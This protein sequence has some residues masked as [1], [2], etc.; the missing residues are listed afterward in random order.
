MRLDIDRNDDWYESEES[1][2]KGMV[3]ELRRIRR[4]F[5]VR[6][7]PVL[8]LAA[9]ITGVLTYKLVTR[10]RTYGAEVVLA[11]R[12]GSLGT[13]DRVGMPVSELKEFVGSVLIPDNKLEELIERRNM[14][15]L[16]NRLGMNWAVAELRTQFEIDVWR[17]SYIYFDPDLP[18]R[19]PSAR[20]GISYYDDDPDSA[21]SL[22]HD[23]ASIV[24][25]SVREHRMEYAG[26]IAT[27]IASDRAGLSKRLNALELERTEVMV[28]FSKAR[29]ANKQGVA[30]ALNLR[31]TEIDEQQKDAEK[32]MTEL[33]TSQDA[34]ADRIA[35][36]G[37]DL[38]IEIVS[39]TRPARPPSRGLLITVLVVIVGIGSLIGSALLIGAFDSRV[40]DVE[41]VE[42]L[43]LPVLGHVP[44]FPGDRVGS[45]E[46]RGVQRTRIPSFRR[47]RSQR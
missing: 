24:V 9:L 25:E 17:N 39:E 37:L 34:I 21:F 35:A 15:R 23:L 28:A 40:H 22:A 7:W 4:R 12:D 20:I 14:M 43:G 44:G 1:T 45:L 31:L 19:D 5:I 3:H 10:K 47:W 41:D 46:A 8:A 2:R 30:Q 16:R 32:M 27:S 18:N 42:R 6:P 29:R 11:L 33:T 13:R 36:A 26:Q 38:V